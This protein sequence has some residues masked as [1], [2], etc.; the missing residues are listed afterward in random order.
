M[1]RRAVSLIDVHGRIRGVIGDENGE[2]KV[3]GETGGPAIEEGE[4]SR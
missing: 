1:S 4:R 3:G 2:K